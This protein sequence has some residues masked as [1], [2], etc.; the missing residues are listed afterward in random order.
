MAVWAGGYGAVSSA[1]EFTLTGAAV[2]CTAGFACTD[3]TVKTNPTTITC[4]SNVCTQGDCC[5]PTCADIEHPKPA[6]LYSR[7]TPLPP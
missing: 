3:S 4:A 5:N 2:D 7:L 1:T 6:V